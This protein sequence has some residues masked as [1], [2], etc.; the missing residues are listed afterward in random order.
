[1]EPNGASAAAEV[2]HIL[3]E[4]VEIL[5]CRVNAHVARVQTSWPNIDAA[6]DRLTNTSVFVNVGM[7]CDILFLQSANVRMG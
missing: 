3:T 1:M 2:D 4:L 7:C 6:M 5:L